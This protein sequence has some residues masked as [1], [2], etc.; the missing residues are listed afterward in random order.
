MQYFNKYKNKNAFIFL[1][2]FAVFFVFTFL[3]N[4]MEIYWDSSQN[5]ELASSFVVDDSFSFLNFPYFYRGYFYSFYIYIATLIFFFLEPFVAF[6]FFNILLFSIIT[7]FI[8]PKFSKI[9][10]NK[11]CSFFGIIIYTLVINIFWSG[12]IQIS[13][14][15]MFSLYGLISAIVII[16]CINK[17]KSNYI[18][19]FCAFTGGLV[20]YATYN[21]R[22]IYLYPALLLIL[23]LIIFYKDI[24]YKKILTLFFLVLGFYCCAIPQIMINYNATESFDFKV[25]TFGYSVQNENLNLFQLR[26]G[27]SIKQYDTVVGEKAK[28]YG[29]ELIKYDYV[30][31]WVIDQ[32]NLESLDSIPQ[33]IS[34]VFKY[35]KQF[36]QIYSNHFI[37]YLDNRFGEIYIHDP[38]ED[39]IIK[40]ILNLIIIALGS[41]NIFKYLKSV[42]IRKKLDKLYLILIVL[43][44]SIMTFPGVP[45]IRFSLPIYFILYIFAFLKPIGKI[46]KFR[47]KINRKGEV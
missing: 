21:T 38:S 10:L 34:L 18:N 15:D 26:K 47:F 23:Y 14:T 40:Y 36:I 3:L 22:T 39:R 35:P 33:Y 42:V 46:E 17:N 44:P 19:Y 5:F 29:D 16:H 4:D 31:E 30:G 45:E 43:I 20:L 2:V 7:T 28:I 8:I 41:F 13:L 37:R 12:L 32:E 24:L 11:D 25:S 27:I 9:I 1:C 6:K